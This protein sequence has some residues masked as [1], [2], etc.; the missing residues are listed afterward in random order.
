[1]FLSKEL[2]HY[3]YK[4]KIIASI[5][6]AFL[7]YPSIAIS[8]NDD[9]VVDKVILESDGKD[10][11]EAKE[12]A[13]AQG[14]IDAFRQLA[15]KLS[16]TKSAE[17]I[18]KTSATEINRMIRG[19][20]VLEEKININ[21]YH[22]IVRYNFSYEPIHALFPDKEKTLE[23]KPEDSGEIENKAVLII[24]VYRE[25]D[26]LKLWQD[27]NKWRIIWYESSLI[28]GGGLVIVPLGD[29]DDRV[30]VDDSNVENANIKSLARMYSRYG[31]VEIYVA[32]AFFNKKAD[33]KPTLEVSLRH[34]LPEKD[35]ITRLDYTIH[36]T[37]NLD[38]LMARASYDIA[39]RL[40][41]IQTIN[42]N[43]IEFDR[44]KEINARVNAT[45]IN[46]WENLRKRLLKH[47]NIVGIKLISISFYETKMT[48]TF[49][50]TTDTLG[51]TLVASGLRVLQDGDS[52]VLILK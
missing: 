29:L 16:P 34:L 46:E 13:F 21:H 47:G 31:A 22:A 11:N 42:P 5:L 51:K 9:F 12:K 30:D 28:S 14:E 41:K 24:P 17:I 18:T 15:T 43:K 33:P 19:Y 52:L 4:Y 10:V 35:E 25:F 2:R 1:M 3:S 26:K 40:Y 39:Q 50:G 7:Y 38:G 37:E 23:K 45:D 20:E 36:S 49:K 27:D 6:L 32:N 48:I 44:L 8:A